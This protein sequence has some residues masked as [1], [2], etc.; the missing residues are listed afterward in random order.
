MPHNYHYLYI[1]NSNVTKCKAQRIVSM[2]KYALAPV[3]PLLCIL[4]SCS[5]MHHKHNEKLCTTEYRTI[6]VSVKDKDSRP[7]LL[8]DYYLE[9]TGTGEIIDFRLEDPFPDSLNRINGQYIIMTDGK[10]NMT[11]A[12]GTDFEF[13]GKIDTTEVINANYVIGNDECHVVLYSG[14]TVI[15]FIK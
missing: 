15:Y 9:K 8:D 4:I 1:S 11:S 14:P 5:G 3:I 10:M 2:K 6:T 13:H 12:S 7:V